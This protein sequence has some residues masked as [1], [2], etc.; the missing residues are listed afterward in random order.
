MVKFSY[1]RHIELAESMRDSKTG[2]FVKFFSIRTGELSWQHPL[3]RYEWNVYAKGS[4]H[5]RGTALTL[6]R[7]KKKVAKI[8]PDFP[9][10]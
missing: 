7:A 5:Q 8:Y 6:K 10:L 3:T 1:K 2:V 9:Y 4:G